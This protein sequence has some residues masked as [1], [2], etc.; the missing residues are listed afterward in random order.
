MLFSD[1]VLYSALA[2]RIAQFIKI[3]QI[4]NTEKEFTLTFNYVLTSGLISCKELDLACCLCG[5]TVETLDKVIFIYCGYPTV[6]DM[7]KKEWQNL[8]TPPNELL[9]IWENYQI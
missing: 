6:C 4:M 5:C 1:I 2:A 8:P 7:Y 9:Q 3:F